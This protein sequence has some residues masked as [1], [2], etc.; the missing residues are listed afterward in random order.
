[1]E[2]KEINDT[3]TRVMINNREIIILGTAHI[4]EHSVEEVTEK[5]I[6]EKPDTVCVEIDEARY[7]TLT[8]GSSWENMDVTRILKEKKG[9]L[10]I[11][12]LVLSSFQKRMGVDVGVTPGEEMIAAI[13]C[14]QENNVPFVLADRNVQITLRRAW[15]KS[16]IVGKAK[17]LASLGGS[18]FAKEEL[19]KE[20]IEKLKERSALSVM[21]DELANYLPTVKE[22]LIDERDQYLASSIFT[23]KGKK[24]IVVVG[25]GH[26]PGMLK[27]L[28]K[29]EIDSSAAEKEHL[30]IVPKSSILTKLS[31]L[32]IPAILIVIGYFGVKFKGVDQLRTMTVTWILLNGIFSALGAAIAA[33][34]P[35]S[36]LVSFL[37]APISSL[38]IPVSSGMFS[39]VVE[40]MMRKPTVK[41]FNALS[42]DI[43]TIKGAYR[44]RVTRSLMVFMFAS[45]GS[46][47][48]TVVAAGTL[49]GQ[50]F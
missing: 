20:D 31:H 5:I 49:T 1:M 50:L 12:N 43:L 23:S 11:A 40:S 45:L 26:V 42:A 39:G 25:A 8:E 21:M 3:E 47:I 37:V 28:E 46:F 32:I 18:I 10:L 13:K 36:V 4:S 44:N 29:M 9:F 27:Q 24:V 33:G 34:H 2:I 22:V 48:G 35:L 6:S 16:G 14:S 41:D 19:S 38:G 7:K 30:D 17:L 15:A